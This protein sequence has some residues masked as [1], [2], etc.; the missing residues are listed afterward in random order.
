MKLAGFTPAILKGIQDTILSLEADNSVGGPCPTCPSPPAQ[1]LFRCLECFD[2]SP[3]CSHCITEGHYHQ[4]FHHI[5]K[6]VGGFFERCS[7][8]DLGQVMYLGHN[9]QERCPRAYAEPYDFVVVHTNGVHKRRILYCNC[10]AFLRLEDRALQL[11]KH[12]LF[13]STLD[14]P[15]TVF[16]FHLLDH[17]HRHSLSAKISAYDYFDALKKHTN[18]AFPQNIPVCSY[19]PNVVTV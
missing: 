3:R 19:F 6:W 18:A 17:F 15:R 11:V 12:Q 7:L 14:K 10:S 5:Q 4:P 13:P 8:Y 16:T 9:G 1:A 2:H